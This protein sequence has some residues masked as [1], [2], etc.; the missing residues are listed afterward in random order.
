MSVVLLLSSS[1]CGGEP[2]VRI[3]DRELTVGCG[4]C[5]FAMPG[6][7]ACPWAA[8][9]DDKHYLMKGALDANHNSHMADGIC[10]MPRRARIT[11]ELRDGLLYV[12]KMTLLA[13]ENVPEDPRFAPTD[14]H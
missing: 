14:I 12:S 3:E 4:A 5:I 10:N 2:G 7:T 6:V 9:I 1:G 11:G 13:A 8:E